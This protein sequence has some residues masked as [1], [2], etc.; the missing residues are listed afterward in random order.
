MVNYNFYQ[1]GFSTGSYAVKKYSGASRYPNE[2]WL[3]LYGRE[4]RKIAKYNPAQPRDDRGRWTDGTSVGGT[5]INSL[6]PKTTGDFSRDDIVNRSAIEAAADADAEALYA[7]HGDSLAQSAAEVVAFDGDSGA[8]PEAGPLPTD[9]E[10]VKSL[11]AEATLRMQEQWGSQTN[12]GIALNLQEAAK[13]QLGRGESLRIDALPETIS[14]DAYETSAYLSDESFVTAWV[15][16][17]YN[18]TQQRLKDAGVSELTVYRGV[19]LSDDFVTDFWGSADAASIIQTRPLSSTSLDRNTAEWFAAQGDAFWGGEDGLKGYVQTMTVKAE[20]VFDVGEFGF[21][22]LEEVI[23][24]GGWHPGKVEVGVDPTIKKYSPSQP[25]DDRGRWTDGA[26]G[27][28]SSGP[29]VQTPRATAAEMESVSNGPHSTVMDDNAPSTRR[30]AAAQLLMDNAAPAVGLSDAEWDAATAALQDYVDNG[31]ISTRVGQRQLQLIINNGRFKTQFETGTS[32]GIFDPSVRKGYESMMFGF[33]RELPHEVR[34]VYG[35]IAPLGEVPSPQQ[36]PHQYG[37]IKVVLKDSVRQRT[38]VTVGDSLSFDKQ[39]PSPALKVDRYSWHPH[40]IQGDVAIAGNPAAALLERSTRYSGGYVEAQIHGG[41]NVTDISR[42]VVDEESWQYISSS[43]IG[44][45]RNAG[46][47]VDIVSPVT[48]YNP[49][50]PRDDRGRWTDGGSSSAISV[51]PMKGSPSDYSATRMAHQA[52]TNDGYNARLSSVTDMY[53]ENIL[54]GQGAWLYGHYTHGQ[55]EHARED[56]AVIDTLKRIQGNPDAKVTVYRTINAHDSGTLPA[57]ELRPGDWVTPS[58]QYAKEHARSDRPST[59]VTADVPAGSLWTDAN[60]LMEWGYDPTPDSAIEKYS[61]SQP[62]DQRGRWTSGGSS[63]SFRIDPVI[64]GDQSYTSLKPEFTLGSTIET[65]FSAIEKAHGPLQSVETAR[66]VLDADSAHKDNPLLGGYYQPGSGEV[67]VI[68][69]RAYASAT[70]VHEFGHLIDTEEFG[71]GRPLSSTHTGDSGMAAVQR[72]VGST[73]YYRQLASGEPVRFGEH[74]VTVKEEHRAYLLNPAESFARVYTQW[75]GTRSGSPAILAEIKKSRERTPF[76]YMDDAEFGPV[77]DAMDKLFEQRQLREVKKYSPSQPRD[78]RGRFASVGSSGGY[79][80]RTA[81]EADVWSRVTDISP[82]KEWTSPSGTQRHWRGTAKYNPTGT[83]H[84]SLEMVF[85]E[86]HDSTD[87][88]KTWKPT[89]MKVEIDP[90]GWN[91]K[92]HVGAWWQKGN[93]GASLDSADPDWVI[94]DASTVPSYR[95]MGLATAALA[96]MRS[97]AQNGAKVDHSSQLLPDGVAFSSVVKYSPSQPRDDRGRWTSGGGGGGAASTGRRL[98]LSDDAYGELFLTDLT[99]SG[100]PADLHVKNDT[101]IAASIEAT[102]EVVDSVEALFGVGNHAGPAAVDDDWGDLGS[103]P[104][105]DRAWMEKQARS[106]LAQGKDM[107]HV[108]EYGMPEFVSTSFAYGEAGYY[109]MDPDNPMEAIHRGMIFQAVNSVSHSWNQSSNRAALSAQLQDAAER[110]G[111]KGLSLE[112]VGAYRSPTRAGTDA[113]FDAYFQATYNRTQKVLAERGVG[114]MEL[115]RG[116]RAPTVDSWG[117]EWTA[118]GGIKVDIPDR[119]LSSWTVDRKVA[120]DFA[121]N[122]HSSFSDDGRTPYVNVQTVPA[123]N[124]WSLG[125][126]GPGAWAEGEV[127][128][129]SHDNDTSVLFDM[130][131]E[132][133]A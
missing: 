54:S 55:P 19:Q 105:P 71:A 43:T 126:T 4:Q 59:I 33:P 38:T 92:A 9:A 49:S 67:H 72:A 108:N 76:E 81:K 7:K 66:V 89:D 106:Q 61:P 96:Y 60:S 82:L 40:T 39:L 27:G 111:F 131:E 122:G 41:L 116:L 98:G 74:N 83:G 3:H 11:Y 114:A 5:G 68:E 102:P 18:H 58:L 77:A 103:A 34:P 37:N 79:T 86:R 31:E 8:Y 109:R 107:V 91:A 129:L 118:E 53:P 26:G 117:A 17:R 14:Y 21:A 50:Q 73:K 115:A 64:Y 63:L 32:N 121:W 36:G 22:S 28:G 46:I 48:K 62:R 110:A 30:R 97:Q 128:V 6:M 132:S 25:R 120:D 93:P 123:K 94:W 80:P 90:R 100:N 20:D 35:Y 15:N 75:V 99:P 10:G 133:N 29:S 45:I 124:I 95:R 84:S 23:I 69:N 51:I 130:M 47:P 24:L 16:Q 44:A 42:I 113:F 56:Q 101:E 104:P 87:G 13:Y 1:T 78:E 125:S 127:I 12:A 112:D 85:F 65:A 70:L 88:G 2:D 57:A 119:P 52:P